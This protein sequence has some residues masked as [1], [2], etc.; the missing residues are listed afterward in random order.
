MIYSNT[1][2][3]GFI[4]NFSPPGVYVLAA[5]SR[6]DLIDPALLRPG[7]LDKCVYCSPPDQVSR[8]EILNALSDSL[9]LADDVDLQ[10][11]ASVTE[12][13]TGADL[14][15]LLYN[16]QLAALHGRLLSG[17]LQDGSSSSDSDLSLSSMVFLNHSSGSDDSA[18]DGECGLDQSLVSLEMSEMIPDESKFNM[19]RL[20]FGSSYESELGNG[21]SSDLSSQCLSAPSSMTRDL[22][23]VPGKDQLCSQPPMFR[24]ASPEGYQ[25]LT[26]EQRDQLRADISI[27]KSRYRSQSG[28]DDSLN[29]P[30]PIKTS[31][32]ISQ[33]H[34]LSALSHTKP[35]ISEDDWKNFA[36]LYESFQN[37]KKRK[38]QSGIMFRPGQKVTLA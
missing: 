37:P 19:Y 7:R 38:N 29:Q 32:A 18:G 9:P 22:P 26:Q 8:L 10:H 35:S 11:V 20:Y 1:I 28:E 12:S 3:P 34:L 14:K 30:G 13:F 4:K 23:G 24:T 36:E 21:T 17:G 5:T 27:I 6:P 16:A 2:S 15:A 25:E 33:L 31:L